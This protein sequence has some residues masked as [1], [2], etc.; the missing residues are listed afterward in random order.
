[1][2]GGEEPPATIGI[3]HIMASLCLTSSKQIR[4]QRLLAN[5]NKKAAIT[6]T[7]RWTR[8]EEVNLA[9]RRLDRTGWT[10]P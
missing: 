7:G 3:Q 10:L 9:F 8:K 1:M 2:R 5:Q 6:A 4:R